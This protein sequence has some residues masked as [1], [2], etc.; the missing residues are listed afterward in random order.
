MICV[1]IARTRNSSMAETMATAVKG[2][3]DLLELRLD[4]LHERPDWSMLFADRRCPVLASCRRPRD[5]GHYVGEERA[6]LALLV[7]AAAAGADW[8]DVEAD[9]FADLPVGVPAKR[10][11]SLHDLHGT[12][13]DVAEQVGAMSRLG[14]DAVKVVTRAASLMDNLTLLQLCAAA[15]VPTIAFCMGPQGL[16]SR[17]LAGRFG[18]PWTYAAPDD[19]PVPAQGQPRLSSLRHTFDYRGIG[20]ATKLFAVVG[21]PIAHSLSPHAHNAAFAAAGMDCRYLPLLV[22]PDDLQDLLPFAAAV[23]IDGLSVT[24]PHKLAVLAYLDDH[25]TAV[26]R[27][28]ACNTVC[29]SDL[30]WRGSNT[31]LPAAM[32][33]IGRLFGLT[34]RQPLDGRRAL[35][36]GA[37]GVAR[38]IAMGLLDA[39]AAVVLAARDAGRRRRLAKDLGC[40]E[41]AWSARQGAA[42]D[43]LVNCTPLGMAPLAHETPFDV[44][45]LPASAAV[46]DTVYRPRQTALI[47]GARDRG[48]AVAGGLDMFID[49]AALQF[50]AFTGRPAPAAAMRQAVELALADDE[51]GA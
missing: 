48:C 32:A 43:L 19:G 40:E 20:P 15:P 9:A 30:G 2:G 5:G 10:L 12:P 14:A 22:H 41:V 38:T 44:T 8:I 28:G 39:G 27:L 49:Q 36:L 25:D 1:T 47:V 7:A 6:R 31:D 3:A 35:V 45:R 23:G 34:E 50:G 17:L 46:F 51:A 37:G 24:L 42:F 13:A 4:H 11:I 21:D 29:R 18:A 26:A 33:T 16:P